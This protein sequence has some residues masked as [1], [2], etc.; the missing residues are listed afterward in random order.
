MCVFLKGGKD[1]YIRIP[2]FKVSIESQYALSLAL[3]RERE[4]EKK[5][6]EQQ[7]QQERACV[8]CTCM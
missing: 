4:K 2:I 3:G 6:T 7:Q 1:Q 8:F 5:D